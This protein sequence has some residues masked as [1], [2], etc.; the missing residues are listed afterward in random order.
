MTCKNR[1]KNA[2]LLTTIAMMSFYAQN[3]DSMFLNVLLRK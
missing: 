1:Y 3:S 2:S